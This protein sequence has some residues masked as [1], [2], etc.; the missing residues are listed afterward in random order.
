MGSGVK[1]VSPETIS[2]NMAAE[3]LPLTVRYVFSGLPEPQI[4][5][6]IEDK[7]KI[8]FLFLNETYA[9]TPK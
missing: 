6:G 8:I 1:G 7:S 2:G 3:V 9:V 4:I 5:G